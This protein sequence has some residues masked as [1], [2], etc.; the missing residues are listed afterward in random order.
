MFESLFNTGTTNIIYLLI[1]VAVCSGLGAISIKLHVVNFSGCL[2]AAIV[3]LAIWIFG[4]WSWFVVILTF[5]LVSAVFTKF[6]YERKRRMGVAQEKGG[7][8]A[9]TNVI[10][11]GGLAAFLAVM[12]GVCLF[13]IPMGYFDI[14]FAGFIG[15]VATAAADTL[16]TEV[17]LLNPRPPRLIT[18][19]SKKVAPGTSGGVSPLGELAII[20]GGL[21]TGGAAFLLQHF[22]LI[23]IGLFHWLD[24]LNFGL[25]IGAK[26]IIIAVGAGFIG[27]TADSIIGATVQALYKCPV[28]GKITEHDI[29][30]GEVTAQLRGH[31]AIDNNIVNF[32]ATAIG[33]ISAFAIYLL[34][35]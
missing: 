3:G 18:N 30:C 32:V 23:G 9:W 11:N 17:G 31:K 27:S 16:A 8:R 7:A 34:L 33:A 10:A 24:M 21:I 6:K 15:V 12:E 29:H 26:L 14:F 2:A 20:M 25:P 5:F 4:H 1:G 28:C 19:L 22:N 13:F 35:F